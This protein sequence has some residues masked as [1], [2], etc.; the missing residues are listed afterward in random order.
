MAL[1]LATNI[2][3][4]SIPSIE[5]IKKNIKGMISTDKYREINIIMILKIY[6]EVYLVSLL[7]KL[8]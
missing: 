2:N 8:I 6:A 7:L 5:Y 3:Q 4:F 1:V